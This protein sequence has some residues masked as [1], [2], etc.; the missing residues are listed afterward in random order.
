MIV[1]KHLNSVPKLQIDLSS[2]LSHSQNLAKTASPDQKQ[3]APTSQTSKIQPN[4]T[5]QAIT[6]P[7]V[8]ALTDLP[9][10]KKSVEA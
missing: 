2:P 3:L 8:E 7:L 4:Q 6:F 9:E 10:T 1:G 5:L